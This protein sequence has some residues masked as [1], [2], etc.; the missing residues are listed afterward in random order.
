[1]IT[2]TLF[3]NKYEITTSNTLIL[4]D[5]GSG[6]TLLGNA[7]AYYPEHYQSNQD[8]CINFTKETIQYLTKHKV[9]YITTESLCDAKLE[10]IRMQQ[11]H[12]LMLQ[13]D[14]N[15]LHQFFSPYDLHV[16]RNDNTITIN[17]IN[18]RDWHNKLSH[19]HVNILSLWFQIVMANN[20][21]VSALYLD[22]PETHLSLSAQKRLVG[23]IV[24]LTDKQLLIATH[25]PYIY[26]DGCNLEFEKLHL[27]T[28]IKT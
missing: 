10:R 21:N 15:E 1:M 24:Q 23:D 18:N 6:K 26:K 13:F 28:K 8:P 16:I 17:N 12:D 25:A 11:T 22:L 20:Q 27:S 14:I 3:K 4:G 2:F 7:L 9:Q 5:N 19:G